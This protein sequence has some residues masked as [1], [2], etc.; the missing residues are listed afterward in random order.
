MYVNEMFVE[1]S[2]H[3]YICQRDVC[4]EFYVI[5]LCTY[6]LKYKHTYKQTYV[7]TYNITT[8]H[9]HS[10]INT[11]VRTYT[12]THIHMYTHT[13]IHTYTH[14]TYMNNESKRLI[15]NLKKTMSCV[16]E[17]CAMCKTDHIRTSISYIRTYIHAHVRTYMHTY[18]R[19][20]VHTYIHTC[21]HAYIQ[22]CINTHMHIY[23]H[24]YIHTN[25]LQSYKHSYMWS[26]YD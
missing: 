25:T 7:R 21:I 9:I 19:T 3:A 14:H 2:A 12:R 6:I 16:K 15:S 13:H 1:I 17:N 11:H 18:I 23:M 26:G 22:T 20:C 10:Y 8:Y 5:H 24:T 4:R